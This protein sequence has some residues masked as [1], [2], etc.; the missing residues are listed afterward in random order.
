MFTAYTV[1][2]GGTMQ[3]QA[4]TTTETPKA[5]SLPIEQRYGITAPMAAQFIGISRT[6]IYE[7]LASGELEG[8]V[9]HGRRVVLVES[10]MRMLGTA[11]STRRE[12][13]PA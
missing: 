12:I 1:F 10:V 4:L 11:P 8:K 6:R 5:A 3:T 2:C 9:I 13:E 7:L